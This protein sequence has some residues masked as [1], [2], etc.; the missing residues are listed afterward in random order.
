MKALFVCAIAIALPLSAADTPREPVGISNT[1]TV[2]CKNPNPGGV[3]RQADGGYV[4]TPQG[5]FDHAEVHGGG[6]GWP[7]AYCYYGI[8]AAYPKNRPA[9]SVH[10]ELKGFKATECSVSGATITCTN[11][12]AVKQ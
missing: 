6:T 5:W 7:A 11:R 12:P 1:I 10:Y 4:E 2:T 3:F 9:Y 8:D